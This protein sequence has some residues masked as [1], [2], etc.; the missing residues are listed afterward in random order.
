LS[1]VP[2]LECAFCFWH[3]LCAQA[4]VEITRTPEANHTIRPWGGPFGRP[5]LCTIRCVTGSET[6]LSLLLSVPYAKGQMTHFIL[7]VLEQEHP[8]SGQHLGGVS[9]N[10]DAGQNQSLYKPYSSA[11]MF[12][13]PDFL[14]LDHF[15]LQPQAARKE[16]LS[17]KQVAGL[18]HCF[19]KLHKSQAKYSQKINEL[20]CLD[21]RY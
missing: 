1:S 8:V 21:I 7:W 19:L 2:K 12:L 11:T 9:C 15:S 17:G 4:P 20:Y 10:W 6:R 14:F 18:C 16:G 5:F 13:L 3:Y